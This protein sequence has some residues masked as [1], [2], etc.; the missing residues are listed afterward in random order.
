MHENE[1]LLAAEAP[2]DRATAE[3]LFR[4]MHTVK[5]NARMLALSHLANTVHASEGCFE[6]LLRNS[7]APP[8]K[9]ALARAVGT[10]LDAIGDYELV[11]RRKLGDVVRTQDAGSERAWGEIEAQVVAVRSGALGAAEAIASLERALARARAV[12]FRDIV[13]TSA[14]M[15]PGLAQELGKVAPLVEADD[16]EMLLTAAWA[17]VMGD[18][19]VH[20]FQNAI[21][22][23]IEGAAERESRGKPGQG[24]ITV[25]TRRTEKKITIRLADDGQGLRVDALREEA[26]DEASTDEQVAARAFAAGVSTAPRLTTISG[27]G[28]GLDAVRSF[29]RGQGGDVA[30]AF[31]GELRDGCRSFELVFELP[32]DAALSEV[33]DSEVSRCVA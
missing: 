5:G 23:G 2:F 17:R 27:R 1:Q 19:M 13:K 14:R 7:V 31:T 8:D 4:N 6:E 24:K 26:S 33:R 15:L 10:V 11:C 30:I 29:V 21:D 9:R 28:V 20:A 18:A 16:D 22:H 25:R 12:P 32:A 3:R